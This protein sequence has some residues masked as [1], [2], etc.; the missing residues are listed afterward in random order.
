MTSAMK[1]LPLFL[2]GLAA[3]VGCLCASA[4]TDRKAPTGRLVAFS[5]MR[6][7][8][9]AQPLSDYVL[10]R[11]PDGLYSLHVTQRLYT[12]EDPNRPPREVLVPQSALDRVAR[13]ILKHEL[14]TLEEELKPPQNEIILDGIHWH[15]QATYD[16]GTRLRCYSDNRFPCEDAL[17]AIEQWLDECYTKVTGLK[18]R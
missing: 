9:S 4:K 14:Y 12:K 5:Y 11:L 15:Y 16:D 7:G 13:I 18:L 10:K 3:L 8:M 1:R 2:L 17:D 6:T